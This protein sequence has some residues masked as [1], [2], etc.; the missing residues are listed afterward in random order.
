VLS[1]ARLTPSVAARRQLSLLWQKRASLGLAKASA[2]DF[3]LQAPRLLIKE[4]GY[5]LQEP[6]EI[7]NERCLRPGEISFRTAGL[8]DQKHR[9]IV[10]A[11]GFQK[12]ERRFTL[13]HEIGHVVM[14]PASHV[15]H[16]DRPLR[17]TERLNPARP[18]YE[19][20]ADVFAAELLMPARLVCSEFLGRFRV[21]VI[22]GRDRSS[23][24][25]RLLSYG[26]GYSI[27]PQEIADNHDRRC[28]LIAECTS[29][30][31]DHFEPLHVSFKVSRS[32]MAIRL[33]ELGLVL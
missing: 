1:V 21:D 32:A 8:V 20:E 12:D 30:G 15:Y 6:A 10:V 19:V 25:S 7:P 23:T 2:L 5:V 24:L 33:G 26:T 4:L 14:H 22:D 27:S 17:G 29:F 3:V 11:R 13:A 9:L 16:R 28:R 18:P 31:P